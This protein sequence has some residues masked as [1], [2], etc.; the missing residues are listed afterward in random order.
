[1]T[2]YGVDIS[3]AVQRAITERVDRLAWHLGGVQ[4]VTQICRFITDTGLIHDG[5][6]LFGNRVP[7]ILASPSPP[8]DRV[9]GRGA[10]FY[11]PQVAIR[12]ENL[13]LQSK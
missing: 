3:D 2:G 7:G 12:I 9:F 13:Y 8:P 6:W 5:T 11:C 10:T 1:V 4:V